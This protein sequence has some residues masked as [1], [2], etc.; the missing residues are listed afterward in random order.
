MKDN[1]ENPIS[2]TF[3]YTPAAPLPFPAVTVS[4][5]RLGIRPNSDSDYGPAAP[6]DRFLRTVLNALRFDCASV[7]RQ[8]NLE[9]YEDEDRE[10]MDDT[11]NLR[12]DTRYERM[13]K[14]VV[15]QCHE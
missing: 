11:L 13:S 8:Y 14:S 3:D 4:P 15:Q 7:G 1:S 10:C 9:E 2:T 12:G 5:A 6:L